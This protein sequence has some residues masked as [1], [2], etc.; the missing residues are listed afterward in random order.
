LNY[1]PNAG[2][3]AHRTLGTHE[4]QSIWEI[5]DYMWHSDV[6]QSIWVPLDSVSWGWF[7]EA[8]WS[9]A[10]DTFEW[11]TIYL[12]ISHFPTSPVPRQTTYPSGEP[13]WNGIQP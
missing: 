1:E 13:G 2:K 4:Q 10:N 6:P 5:S 7:G 11:G 9:D 3:S 8:D 12:H